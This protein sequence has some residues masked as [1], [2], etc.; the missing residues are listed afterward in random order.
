MKLINMSLAL[1]TERVKQIEHIIGTLLYYTRGLDNTCLLKLRT[2]STRS[3]P[4]EQYE[5][6]VNQFLDYMATYPNAVV[7]FHVSAM[8]LCANNNA[9]YL[10]EP[11]VRSRSAGHFSLGIIPSKCAQECP[12]VP[13]HVDCNILKFVAASE[14]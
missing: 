12:N 9:S 10:N 2:M 13:I 3:D 6:N 8:I 5:K 11:Q 1:L 7:R 14:A 4:T